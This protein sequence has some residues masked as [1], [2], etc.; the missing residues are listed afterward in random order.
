LRLQYQQHCAA[1]QNNHFGL[2]VK[3]RPHVLSKPGEL[4]Q[5]WVRRQFPVVPARA[6][7]IHKLQGGM[8]DEIIYKY[9]ATQQQ[10]LVYLTLSRVTAITGLH[11]ITNKDATFRFMHGQ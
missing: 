2:R 8:L 6:I 5:S 7:T 3:C 10:K 11:V 9:S 1:E 4:P